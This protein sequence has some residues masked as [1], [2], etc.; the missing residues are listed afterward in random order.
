MKTR[1]SDFRF[2]FKGYGHYE[3]TYTS[4][5]TNKSWKNTTAD[6]QLIDYTKNEDSP[7]LKDL[8]ELKR[9]CKSI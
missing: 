4:P 5:V 9:L 3:V 1:L 7:K 6:M 8:N 2:R